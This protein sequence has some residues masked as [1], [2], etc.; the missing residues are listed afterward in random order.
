M[1]CCC[2]LIGSNSSTAFA[3]EGPPSGFGGSSEVTQG[4]SA[5]TIYEDGTYSNE[6][7]T[8]TGD[9]E[10]ALR[11]DGATVTLSDITV[12]KESGATS[13]TEN[14]DFY[15]MN[16]AL[17]ATNG[18]DVTI[19]NATVSSS[20]QNGNGVFSYGSGTKVTISDST[21]TTTKD[22]SGG[23]QTTGGGTTYAYDLTVDT[24]GNSSAAIRS[25][26]G[27]GTVVVEGG[28]YTSNGYNSPAVYSTADISV[29]NARL[30]ANNSEALVI[31]GK[32]S[33][34]LTDCYVSGNMSDTRGT[35]SDENVHNVMIYQSMSGDAAV[36]KSSFSMTGGELVSENGD[37]FY[38]TNTACSLYL[39]DVSIVNQENDG[40]FLLAAGNSASH[41]WGSA[42]SNGAEV[43]FTADNQVLTG[44]IGVDTISSLDM[45]LTNGSSFTGTINILDNEA[46]GA[47]KDDNVTVTIEEGSTWILTGDCTVSELNNQGNIIYND[48]TITID[49]ESES[50]KTD[51][52][53]TDD[54][55]EEIKE[56]EEI[57]NIVLSDTGITANGEAV[58]EDE[59]AAM[60]T[61]HDIIY[62]EDKDTY[63]SGNKYGEG[64][65]SDKHTKEE[66][67]A[68]TVLHIAEAGVY[69]ISGSL[70]AGQIKVDLGEDASQ[71]SDAVVTLI[72]D[73]VDITCT[74]APAIL[75]YRVYECDGD[76]STETASPEVNTSNAGANLVIADG[77]VNKVNGSHVAKIY[78][79]N[80]SQKKL[81]K[82]D[83]AVYS[84]MSMNINGEKKDTG[85]LYVNA[86]CEGISSDLHLTIYGGNINIFSQDDGINASEDE[87]SVATVNGGKLHIVAGLGTEGDGVDSNGWL[88]INGGVVIAAANPASDS[89]LDSDMGSY[90]N[91]GTVV[92]LG[93][94]MDWAESESKQVT[95][96]LQFASMRSQSEAIVIM[97]QRKEIV[98]AYEPAA[99]E[100]T[101]VE[102]RNYQGA[103][104]SCD[105]L[106]KGETY[107][108]YLGG[109][110]VGTDDMGIY[111]VDNITSYTDGVQQMYTGTDVGMIFDGG[112]GF[113]EGEEG[114]TR[115][116]MPEGEEGMT[117]PEMPGGEEKE[118]SVYF[119]LSDMVNAFSG[120]TDYDGEESQ[121]E[122][123]PEN[124]SSASSDTNTSTDT[125]TETTTTDTEDT[126]TTTDTSS[127]P[128]TI[129]VSEVANDMVPLITDASHITFA[130]SQKNALLKSELLN[131]YYGQNLQ[132]MAYLGKGLGFTIDS[133]QLTSDVADLELSAAIEEMA[134]FA[135]GFETFHFAPKKETEL[136][137]QIGIH[138][139]VGTENINKTAYVFS[140]NLTTGLYELKEISEVNEIGNIATITS[141]VTDIMIMIV[142]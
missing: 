71:D 6:T 85:I 23:I 99:D 75:F 52:E 51:S 80:A 116:E 10:N 140:K 125:S 65:T 60:Y 41:G 24:S 93:S 135:E 66:A 56:T 97:N 44:D 18:A 126:S 54:E 39:S 91:G 26:R 70:S 15:G 53:E 3:L 138:I 76:W 27:G 130:L 30:T 96:N 5:N 111:D 90:V 43:S 123:E 34:S 2:S 141:E 113:P 40:Y 62:Y 114:M 1:L 78:K 49:G 36:G 69:R 68:H 142:E 20:A 33:I 133:S 47:A 58:G 72:L 124:E 88:V 42:G 120:V 63:D 74:V 9:D 112:M 11:I 127:E 79:D 102:L 132:L 8:S 14:G 118:S 31:E 77:S 115:P 103:I 67:D 89:G 87:V 82:Q 25:D 106:E 17:L 21:I 22:N 73:H 137:Y 59:S 122:Q 100:I 108:V 81:W 32:N 45:N 13:N 16:A 35:S 101:G 83:G 7:Y 134:G 136:P 28:T 50:E 37:M 92:A 105:G 86:D 84:Y 38:I 12:N 48:Y 29:R 46:G 57:V 109:T 121:E 128:S 131:K 98:F 95:M 19:S 119:Y 104:I 110:L 107:F 94:T 129:S 64:T 117:L 61:A 4:S 139:N 55:K